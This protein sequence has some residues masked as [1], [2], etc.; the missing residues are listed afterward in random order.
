MRVHWLGTNE[1][2]SWLA[3]QLLPNDWNLVPH[4]PSDEIACCIV[5]GTRPAP[6]NA[7]VVR[8]VDDTPE[9]P[10][11]PSGDILVPAK[12]RCLL[13]QA[14][15]LARFRRESQQLETITRGGVAHD[16]RGAISVIALVSQVLAQSPEQAS[17]SQKLQGAATKLEGLL[18]DL[19]TLVT[20]RLLGTLD[21][22]GSSWAQEIDETQ[23]WFQAVQRNRQVEFDIVFHSDSAPPKLSVI[24][25]GAL[26]AAARLS[27]REAPLRLQ[28]RRDGEHVLCRV[29]VDTEH[30]PPFLEGRLEI[31]V[32]DWILTSEQ[33]SLFR[34]VTSARLVARL[35]G[36]TKVDYQSG[37][38]Q[39][40]LTW[41]K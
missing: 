27:S 11:S 21:A 23:K 41:P 5:Q 18:A 26:D 14:L 25:R 29:S 31:P 38:L 2:G 19:E 12:N 13:V 28:A 33:R 22:E 6:P 1:F 17:L 9:K 3:E 15:E 24:L 32:T 8:V 36:T 30:F 10:S 20:L 35:G 39:L 7:V 34:L 40:T 16:M 37:T 4:Q